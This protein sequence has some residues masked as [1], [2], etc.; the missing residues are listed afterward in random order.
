MATTSKTLD[1]ADPAV[2]TLLGETDALKTWEY[3]RQSRTPTTIKDIAAAVGFDV[4]DIHRYLD[5]LLEQGLLDRVRA[6]KPRKSTGYRANCDQIVVAFD[7]HDKAIVD[8]LMTMADERSAEHHREVEQHTDPE[9]HSS[10]GFR[11]RQASTHHV[12]TEEFAEL[13]RRILAVISFL[14]MPRTPPRKPNTTEAPGTGQ[15]RYCNQ[16]I[17]ITLDPLVGE[18]LPLPTIITTPRSKLD[19]WDGSKADSGGLGSLSPREREVALALADGLS[20]ATIASRLK[21]T[22]NTVSTLARRAYRKLGVSS[23]AELT[24]RLTGHGRPT[25]GEE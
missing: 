7:E 1:F 25:P 21:I 16:A 11:F 22:V 23:Q 14:N 13:R 24:A 15:A 10:A 6:R 19:Q 17:S 12:S 5:M 8:Q 3:I 20:R 2:M 18:L 9:F 4:N